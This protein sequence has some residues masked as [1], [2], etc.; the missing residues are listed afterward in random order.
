ML[1]ERLCLLKKIIDLAKTKNIP[2]LIDGTQ[3][4]PHSIL[5]MQ[6]LIVIFMLFLVTKCMGLMD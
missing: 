5:D 6:D 2:V 4:A 1:L 3:G